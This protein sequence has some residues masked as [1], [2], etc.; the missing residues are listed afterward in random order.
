MIA[1]AIPYFPEKINADVEY[2]TFI[3]TVVLGGYSL[4]P[5]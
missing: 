1:S 2:C 5:R 3:Y 4:A